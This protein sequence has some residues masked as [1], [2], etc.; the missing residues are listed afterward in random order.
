MPHDNEA[1]GAILGSILTESKPCLDQARKILGDAAGFYENKKR[2][3]ANS[4]FT[5]FYNPRHQRIYSCLCEMAREGIGI[6]LISTTRALKQQKVLEEIG[7]EAYL[8]ELMNSI[9]TTANLETWCHS[10]RDDAVFRNLITTCEGI[11]EKCY[12]ADRPAAAILN[13]AISNFNILQQFIS[14]SVQQR[15]KTLVKNAYSSGF[16]T[17]DYNDGG[18]QGRKRIILKGSK[19]HGKTNIAKQMIYAMAKQG[20]PCLFF[21]GEREREYEE[22]DLAKMDCAPQE[23]Q[24][25][26]GIAG[27]EEYHPT[28]KARENYRAGIGKFITIIDKLGAGR[29]NMFDYVWGEMEK[30]AQNGCKLFILDNL[31]ILNGSQGKNKFDHQEDICLKI[32]LFKLRYDVDVI[33]IVH[34]RKGKGFESASGV[35]QIEDLADTLIRLIRL[36]DDPHVIETENFMKK[37]KALA[38]TKFPEA[39]K[40]KITAILTF[41]KVKKGTKYTAFL[42]WDP[43]REISIE[44]SMMNKAIEYQNKGFFV[45]HIRRMNDADLP[46]PEKAAEARSSYK[47]E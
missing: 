47:D 1:A 18:F 31:A 32:D 45:R 23:I 37:S 13:D 12:S 40:E 19:N 16:F 46:E 6:D 26:I 11:T 8:L 20:V 44:V 10:V 27:R 41:E 42:E 43:I 9:A 33:L 22:C 17:Y 15:P 7:G 36:S 4:N 39:V 24:H 14:Y 34:P 5:V 35:G 28:S 30:A 29:Q 3:Q 25:R 38:K 21:S 2:G